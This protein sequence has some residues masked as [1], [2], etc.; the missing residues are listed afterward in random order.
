MNFRKLTLA[1]LGMITFST[2]ALALNP[3]RTYKQTPDK[4]NMKYE[5]ISVKVEEGVVLNAWYFPSENSKTSEMMIISHNGEGNMGDYLNQVNQFIAL[6]Y[7]VVIYDYRGFGE[8]TEFEIDN[9]M[10]IYPHFQTDLNGMIEYIRVKYPAKINLYGFGLGGGLS[11]GVGYNRR[12]VKTII[13]DEP[14]LSMTWLEEHQDLEVPFAGYDKRNE[15]IYALDAEAGANLQK[16]LIIVGSQTTLC[17]EDVAKELKS[18]NKK[19][20]EVYVAEGGKGGESNF[21]AD[22]A[23]YFKAIK[24]FLKD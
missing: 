19:M 3:S 5:K 6:G 24:E 13:A 11:L 14:F 15:P 7:Q 16:I 18:K 2:A 22:K 8:S 20:I 10:Y 12:E 21:K 4:Y 23:G 1:L 9:N 17:T